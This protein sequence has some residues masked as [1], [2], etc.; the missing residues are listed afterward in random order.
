[1]AGEEYPVLIMH[2]LKSRTKGTHLFVCT[3]KKPVLYH[4]KKLSM[5][6]MI[7]TQNKTDRRLMVF[8]KLISLLL[9]HPAA[10]RDVMKSQSYEVL[11]DWFERIE[12]DIRE[13]AEIL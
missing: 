3:V 6:F 4:G 8:Y 12:T 1:M 5:I 11:M 7:E 9:N 13:T 10:L 2:P